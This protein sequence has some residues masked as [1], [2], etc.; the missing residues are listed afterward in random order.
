MLCPPRRLLLYHIPTPL[1]NPY[2]K[3]CFRKEGVTRLKGR[4]RAH[5][6]GCPI[7]R[8]AST[9]RTPSR[10]APRDGRHAERER[11]TDG[12]RADAP[13]LTE[14]P[15]TRYKR[16]RCAEPINHTDGRQNAP[17]KAHKRHALTLTPDPNV[18]RHTERKKPHS[19][20]E[21]LAPLSTRHRATI[22]R[23]SRPFSRPLS[24]RIFSA[25]AVQ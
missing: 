19:E 21:R 10:H 5:R 7:N 23:H 2:S 12:S 8:T 25:L 15:K 13:P 4:S 14:A 20:R 17:H 6:S 11:R 16:T 22:P 3:F 9:K 1:V 24:V 18:K